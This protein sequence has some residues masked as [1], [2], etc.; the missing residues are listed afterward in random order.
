MCSNCQRSDPHLVKKK[1]TH[2]GGGAVIPMQSVG[3]I[4]PT[5]IGK[6][7][8]ATTKCQK[9]KAHK[10]FHFQLQL[11]DSLR[12]NNNNNN[13]SP[14]NYTLWVQL[15]LD[16]FTSPPLPKTLLTPSTQPSTMYWIFLFVLHHP[17]IPLPNPFNFQT[18]SELGLSKKC[19]FF[20]SD[21][22]T[23][24]MPDILGLFMGG[25]RGSQTQK[26]RLTYYTRVWTLDNC[27]LY[28]IYHKWIVRHK[29]I[30][31]WSV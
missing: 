26:W 9:T 21:L 14:K 2:G 6:N 10:I 18:I 3:H 20:L 28:K 23:I 27:C 7:Q 19:D 22:W 29:L 8:K 1:K 24:S 16:F 17:A 13:K 5:L 15:C 31:K 30:W 4:V 11:V 12:S 25:K